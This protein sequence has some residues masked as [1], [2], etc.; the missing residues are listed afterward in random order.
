MTL[1]IDHLIAALS[2][3]TNGGSTVDSN[4]VADQT[5]NNLTGNSDLHRDDSLPSATLSSQNSSRNIERSIRL[6]KFM[7]SSSIK[8]KQVKS[9]NCLFCVRFR[10]SRKQIELHLKE[11]KLCEALYLRKFKVT[12]LDGILIKLFRCL[13]C[14]S[15]GNFQLKRHLETYSI[16]NRFY[17]QR[18]G[19]DDWSQLKNKLQNLTKPSYSSR[20]GLKRQL[21]NAAFQSKKKDTKTVTT[22]LNEFKKSISL[23]N[24]RLCVLCDQ[25]HLSSSALEITNTDPLF[26]TLDLNNKPQYRRQRK[27]WICLNCK[28]SGKKNEELFCQPL[29]KVFEI[30][31]RQI[32]YP[33]TED[34]DDDIEVSRDTL[35]LIPHSLPREQ[36]QGRNFSVHMYKN[37]DPTNTFIS[38][39]YTIRKSKSRN[40]MQTYT[41]EKF[42]VTGTTDYNQ[43][44]KLLI[45][46]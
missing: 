34:Q 28:S 4:E 21:V 22:S 7:S 25:F 19:V 35:I 36:L 1:P 46:P 20:R 16:C 24:F 14:G 33:T 26:E 30:E 10:Y 13:Q 31:N 38:T 6:T 40:Y 5:G 15:K 18:F 17:K 9:I 37:P 11:S 44:L 2:Q 8:R 43:F 39:L 3:S 41:K 42:L 32:L 23:A 27:F 29:M 12:H 45:H